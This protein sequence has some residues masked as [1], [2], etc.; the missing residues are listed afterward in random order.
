MNEEQC[1]NVLELL[2]PHDRGC[3]IFSTHRIYPT[4]IPRYPETRVEVV[5]K[6]WVARRVQHLPTHLQDKMSAGSVCP[7]LL[8]LEER[9]NKRHTQT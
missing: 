3:V 6:R 2:T 1:Y 4:D 5:T 8:H 9:A 7:T